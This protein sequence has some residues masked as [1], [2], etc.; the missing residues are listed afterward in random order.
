[1]D[2]S[3]QTY[4]KENVYHGSP[5]CPVA[6]Y[7]RCYPEDLHILPSHWHEE[8]E[9][10]LV[11][12]GSLDY[13]IDMTTYQISQGDI[14]LI[15][16]DTLHAAHQLPERQAVTDSAVFH[17]NLAGL[18]TPDLC[19][20]QFIR[21]LQNG[22]YA[23]QPVVRPGDPHYEELRDCLL[24]LWDCQKAETPCQPLALK[25]AVLQLLQVIFLFFANRTS[26]RRS[27]NPYTAKVKLALSYIQN[28][29][30]EPIT[31]AQLASL[32]GFS[33]VH[34]MNIFKKAVGTTCI[35][36][37][38]EYRLALAAIDLRETDHPVVQ[39]A[40]DHGFQTISYF[41]RAFRRKYHATPSAYRRGVTEEK[42]AL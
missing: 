9:V 37:L 5:D 42:Q 36:Y 19:T 11:R 41:N 39:V 17:L 31:I 24:R 3:L 2:A 18:S 8:M 15:P 27:V 25:A 13:T 28:H 29:H 7:H 34:F 38:I 35:D 1:M 40:M 22:E 32:S 21:P 16:P 26:E 30:T 33:Q 14:L 6:F 20:T 23:V 10:A 12:S 4:L